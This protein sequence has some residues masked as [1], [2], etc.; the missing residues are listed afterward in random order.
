MF[1]RRLGVDPLASQSCAEGRNCPDILELA[2]GDFAVIGRDITS[3]AAEL[4]AESG[5]GPSE[6]MVRIP[7]ALLVRAR[8][9]IPTAG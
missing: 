6:R 7:R 5:C 8:A 9:D 3:A 4:P 1:I 2:D